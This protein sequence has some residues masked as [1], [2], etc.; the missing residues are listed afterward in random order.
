MSVIKSYKNK[1]EEKPVNSNFENC[2]RNSNK[3]YYCYL[4]I[5]H[6]T[7]L[8]YFQGQIYNS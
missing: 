7:G 1:L 4:F 5:I 3:D 6:Y 8:Q 2:L